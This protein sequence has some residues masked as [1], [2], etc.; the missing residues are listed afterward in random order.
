MKLF[1]STLLLLSILCS[2]IFLSCGDDDSP[3]SN[4]DNDDTDPSDTV[5]ELP[6]A[7]DAFAE[8]VTIVLSSDG[9]EITIETD[10]IPNHESPYWSNTTERSAV[11]PM[12]NTLITP[13]AGENHPLFVEPTVTSFEMMAPGNIDD[14]NGSFSLTVDAVPGLASSSSTTGAEIR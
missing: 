14:F 6:D 13:A 1:K 10:G 12:G 3:S 9:S 7:F 4:N 8:D 5:T 2:T 11:D